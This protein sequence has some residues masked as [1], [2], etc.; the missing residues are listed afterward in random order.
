[1]S[2]YAY[3]QK[4]EDQLLHKESVIINLE[5]ELKALREAEKAARELYRVSCSSEERTMEPWDNL[6][7]AL[8]N[9]DETRQ[10]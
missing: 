3:Y 1:M 4:L 9:L 10:K 7:K 2:Y 8:K 5:K 6:S